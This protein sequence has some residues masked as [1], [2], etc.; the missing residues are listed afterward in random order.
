M[1]FILGAQSEHR[2]KADVR[3][4]GIVAK[5]SSQFVH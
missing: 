2:L 3:V 1:R 4:S 5:K